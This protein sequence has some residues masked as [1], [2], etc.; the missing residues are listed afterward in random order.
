VGGAIPQSQ[1]QG[2]RVTAIASIFQFG[3]EVFFARVDTGITGPADLAD[4]TVAV[5]GL[6]WQHELEELLALAGLTMDDIQ[7]VEEGYDMTPF[8]EGEVEVWSGYLSDEV[9]RA[10][11]RGLEL[12]T[13]PLYEYGID[14]VAQRF[15]A[16]QDAL[17]QD[18]DLAIRTL[19]ASLRGWEWAVEHPSEAVDL[20]LEMFPELAD[21][22]EFHLASFNAII[23]LVRPPG[24]RIG[25]ID[26]EAWLANQVLAGIESTEGLCT[27]AILEA[28][29]K[30]E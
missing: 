27:T 11:Q 19:R 6:A 13:L 9:V 18:P 7:P 15:V 10:R 28:A 14:T 2:T 1:A 12:V 23:P 3:P 22:R 25:A 24:V 4:R 26:C 17:A 20:M 30:E 21:Q 5:K 29:W 16:G 8:F